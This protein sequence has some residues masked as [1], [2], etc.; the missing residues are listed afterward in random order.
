MGTAGFGATEMKWIG[1]GGHAAADRGWRICRQL[2]HPQTGN[3]SAQPHVASG[4]HNRANALGLG[5]SRGGTTSRKVVA[6]R[7]E[8]ASRLTSISLHRLLVLI[9]EQG[10]EENTFELM[11]RFRAAIYL[12]PHHRALP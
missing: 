8:W 4:R 2:V 11:E 1:R 12:H 10:R 5:N 7:P 9:C 6:V 3:L